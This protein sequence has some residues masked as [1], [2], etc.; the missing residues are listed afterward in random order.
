MDDLD[1]GQTLTGFR[2]GQSVFGRYTLTRL[3]GRGGMGVVWLAHDEKLEQD[4]ALK[5]LPELVS[6]DLAAIS[7]LKRETRRSL[8]LTHP[9]IVRIYDFVEDSRLAAVSM[10]FVDGASLTQRR[11]D[12]PGQVFSPE[13]LR[14]WMK[15]LCEALEYAHSKAR[16]V[17]RD[18]KP[19]NLMVDVRG[20]LKV[21]D[22]GISA[23]LSDTA[24]RASKQVGSSGTPVYMSPQQMMGDKPA[25]TDDIYSLGATLYELLTGKPPFY[26]GMVDL[27]RSSA[28]TV[29]TASRLATSPAS[30]PP[31]PSDTTSSTP[32]AASGPATGVC[33]SFTAGEPPSASNAKQ[34]SLFFRFRPTSV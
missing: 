4:V 20:D 9:H 2:A 18:L 12:Q 11:L 27:S 23:T 16:I 21:A 30:A 28:T 19:A 22:F 8:Q 25:P 31:M 1:L 26:T 32:A 5:F 7:D 13:Q 17:H 3:L 29:S 10:E 33:G 24:T 14:P 6:N 15:Q 34:S